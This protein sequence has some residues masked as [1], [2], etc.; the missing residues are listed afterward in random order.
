MG[1][2]GWKVVL[3]LEVQLDATPPLFR[4]FGLQYYALSKGVR[5]I[6]AVSFR[7]CC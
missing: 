5:G 4:D 1:A 7:D 6:L 3:S 2:G